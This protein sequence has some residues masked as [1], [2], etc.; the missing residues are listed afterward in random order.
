MAGD[1]CLGGTPQ[2]VPTHPQLEVDVS[3]KPVRQLY[4]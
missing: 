4:S 3:T 1:L 2:A